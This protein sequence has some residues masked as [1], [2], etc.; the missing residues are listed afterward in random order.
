MP[1]LLRPKVFDLLAH[2]VRHRERVVRREELV[3][4]VWQ[5]TTVG[6]GSLSGLVNE[7]R[8]ALGEDRSKSSVIRTVHAR[9]YQFVG[10]V[11]E[12]RS[13]ST[14]DPRGAEM[15]SVHTESESV[16]SEH[17]ALIEHVSERGAQGILFGRGLGEGLGDGL[18]N[19]PNE[20][21][22]KAQGM[23]FEVHNLVAPDA[24]FASSRRFSIE[25]LGAMERTRGESAVGFALP[26]PARGWF[27]S[28]GV[29]PVAGG[30]SRPAGGP[31]GGIVAMAEMVSVLAARKPVVLTIDSMVFAG[32]LFAREIV[33]FTNSLGAAPV[34]VVA[35]LGGEEAAP[36]AASKIH[37]VLCVDGG[38]LDGDVGSLSDVAPFLARNGGRSSEPQE[39]LDAAHFLAEGARGRAH[40][41]RRTGGDSGHTSE[42][43]A[44][45]G[46]R[47]VRRARDTAATGVDR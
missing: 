28:G 29:E 42:A 4:A 46:I 41:G 14:Q 10:R 32:S 22:E 12:L 9:G 16:F 34:L 30:W 17:K 5:R 1:I 26:L 3:E 47:S 43:L 21:A 27:D 25:L 33:R 11:E 44:K 13:R 35:L 37:R 36:S 31:P 23:G 24:A 6:P 20:L 15:H 19:G 7:L 39:E 18:K 40:A 8:Q 38:F 45:P 2:L